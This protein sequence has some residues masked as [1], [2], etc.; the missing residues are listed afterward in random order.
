MTDKQIQMAFD[1]GMNMLFLI[2]YVWIISA[3][4][5][6][7]QP[8]EWLILPILAWGFI[9]FRWIARNLLGG[10]FMYVPT[11]FKKFFLIYGIGSCVCA[12]FGFLIIPILM[13]Y[14]I[15]QIAIPRS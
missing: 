5:H 15:M 4:F 1:L 11:G 2:P 3:D 9:G 14:Q 13:V 7:Y 10:S 6:G 8:P 12:V